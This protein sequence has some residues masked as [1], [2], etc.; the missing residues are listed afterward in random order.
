MAPV[1]K[2]DSLVLFDRLKTPELRKE[3][4]EKEICVFENVVDHNFVDQIRGIID[5]SI[6]ETTDH[7]VGFSGSMTRIWHA[8]QLDPLISEIKKAGVSLTEYFSRKNNSCFTVLAQRDLASTP[9][10][11]DID[12]RWHFDSF[13]RQIKL[14]LFLTDVTSSNGPFSF[15]QT[16]SK[17]AR[18]QILYDL[19]FFSIETLSSP[20]R[21][22][23]SI[24]DKYVNSLLSKK[25][26]FSL[27]EVQV[28]KGSLMLVNTS[29]YMHRAK[30]IENGYRYLLSLYF[31]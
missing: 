17:W 5:K 9:P 26:G 6:E 8:D 27:R 19:G 11:R 4:R 25:S 13:R 15:I 3:F 24:P 20:T 22:Y 7:E 23:Q 30:P 14:F 2:G 18:F 12:N 10:S 28:P 16:S 31:E 29:R 21:C 1:I